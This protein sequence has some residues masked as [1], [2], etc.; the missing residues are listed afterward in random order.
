MN[1]H[2]DMVWYHMCRRLHYFPVL[3]GFGTL[4]AVAGLAL[5]MPAGR[6]YLSAFASRRTLAAIH[7]WLRL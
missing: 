4:L 2:Y 7:M 5:R 6:A 3:A 1:Y